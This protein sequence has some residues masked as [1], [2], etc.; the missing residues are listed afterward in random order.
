MFQV[1]SWAGCRDEREGE[2]ES[3]A[4]LICKKDREIAR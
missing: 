4:D 3:R 1:G 2:E